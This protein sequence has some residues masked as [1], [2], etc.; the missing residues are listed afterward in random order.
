M[1]V[2][3]D[4]DLELRSIDP[5]KNRYRVYGLTECRNLFGE[6][7]LRIVWGRLGTRRMRERSEVFA[8]RGALRRR[9]DELLALRRR[10]G[11]V[12]TSTPRATARARAE[13]RVAAPTK[14]APSPAVATARAI[15]EAHGLA[16]DDIVAVSL[17]SRWREATLA[18]IR[19][20][21]TNGAGVLDLVDASTLASLFVE[22][23]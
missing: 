8:D 12:W 16:L 17:V 20:A 9:R 21:Q 11:Y 18:I 7:C 23:A 5:A 2:D 3:H 1:H 15:V 4:E 13:A 10:H 19:Y 22:A 14:A 6:L